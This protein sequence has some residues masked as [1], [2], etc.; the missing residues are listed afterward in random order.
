MAGAEAGLSQPEA[1]FMAQ[2]WIFESLSPSKLSLSHGFQAELSRH[3]TKQTDSTKALPL[4]NDH[5]GSCTSKSVHLPHVIEPLF[6][7]RMTE[8]AGT[9][10]GNSV[11]L[12]PFVPFL[13][14]G[15]GGRGS[16]APCT[17]VMQ[18]PL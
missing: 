6:C 14:Q 17:Y 5:P 15:S 9:I 2:A 18:T 13:L 12:V 11:A 16:C 7:C 3:N 1:V 4:L 8:V 10:L